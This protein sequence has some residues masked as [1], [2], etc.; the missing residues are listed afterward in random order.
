MTT[1]EITPKTEPE[2]EREVVLQREVS[3]P[4]ELVWKAMTV[5]EHQ[6]RWWGPD[7]FK[8][9]GVVMD[10]RVGGAWTF[11]MVGPDG[12]RYPNHCV[13]KEITPPSKLVFD[14]GDG[15]SVWFEQSFTLQETKS[16]RGIGTLITLRNLFPNK[17]FRDEVVSKQNAIEGGKQHLAK[18]DA[19]LQTMQAL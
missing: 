1:A 16:E 8:N 4:R 13:F 15:N 2:A 12:T 7:G 9:V 5:P 18:L 11:E 14:H 19:Y 17:A 10:F 3:F 6:N